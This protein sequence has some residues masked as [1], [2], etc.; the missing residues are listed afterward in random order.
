[1]STKQHDHQLVMI[2]A[3]GDLETAREDFAELERRLKHGMELRAGSLVTKNAAGEA[4]IEEAANRHG[5]VG[6]LVGAGLGLL[7]GLVFEPVILA[8][9]VALSLVV[10]FPGIAL[11]LPRTMGVM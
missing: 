9:L 7:V 10:A 2:A 8:M 3:Y 5:R 11:W 1:M 4:H 6:T